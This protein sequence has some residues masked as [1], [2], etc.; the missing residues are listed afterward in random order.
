M[1][2]RRLS[3][4]V[5][6]DP[7]QYDPA[8][9]LL[10]NIEFLDGVPDDILKSILPKLQYQQFPKSAK[11]LFQGEIANRL[12]LVC[13]GSVVITAKEKGKSF[14]LAEL[15]PPQYFGEISLLRPTSA[16]ATVTAGEEGANVLILT[17][18]V[19]QTVLVLKIPDIKERL[20]KVIDARL[21]QKKQVKDAENQ[22]QP[23]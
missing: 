13:K 5:E 1:E 2:D 8:L 22:E 17:Y 19:F 23:E 10:K 21:A 14:H 9:G 18:E 6:L 11:I 3:N 16:T 12:F 7:K 20:Q 15:K 4:P